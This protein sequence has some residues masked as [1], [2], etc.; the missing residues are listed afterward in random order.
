MKQLI[1]YGD[2]HFRLLNIHLKKYKQNAK[3]KNLH[4]LRVELKKI[5]TL[6]DLLAF[7]SKQ[8][9]MLSY[10]PLKHIF[11]EAGYI[12]EWDV[13]HR[14]FKD[15]GLEKLEKQIIPKPE[16]REQ[17]I[18]EFH[19]KTGGHIKTVKQSHKKISKYV[20]GVN[21]ERFEKIHFANRRA[22]KQKAI[23]KVQAG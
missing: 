1:K 6:F 13:L 17:A 20:A 2:K 4:L 7:N 15:Y 22:I 19:H 3:P 12:R 5:K 9:N 11:R 18:A 21:K 23:P 10:K 14:L 8:F 16:D